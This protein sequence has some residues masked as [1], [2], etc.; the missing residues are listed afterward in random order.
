MLYIF[1]DDEHIFNLISIAKLQLLSTQPY[2]LTFDSGSSALQYFEEN[3]HQLK[4]EKIVIFLDINMPEMNGFEFLQEYKNKFSD[5]LHVVVYMLS[6][7]I[8]EVDKEAA[9][10]Y[11]MVKGFYSKPFQVAFLDNIGDF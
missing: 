1:I 6:S 11:S 2:A 10:V 3:I 9:Y 8:A 5:L 7:S 4:Y